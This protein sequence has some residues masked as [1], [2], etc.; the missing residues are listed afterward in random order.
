MVDQEK[1]GG[2]GNVCFDEKVTNQNQ[3]GNKCQKD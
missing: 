3:D 2:R 1:D